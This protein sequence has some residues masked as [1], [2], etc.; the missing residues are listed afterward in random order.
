M[1]AAYHRIA[2]IYKKTDDTSRAVWKIEKEVK[3]SGGGGGDGWSGLSAAAS[4]A[5]VLIRELFLKH[6]L[7]MTALPS[8]S[9]VRVLRKRQSGGKRRR[10]VSTATNDIL[11][12]ASPVEVTQ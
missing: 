6:G 5:R 3:K 4:I 8:T 1:E 2:Q 7:E 9:Q 11:L 12:N 10:R